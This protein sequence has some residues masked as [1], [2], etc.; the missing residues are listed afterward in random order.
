[1]VKF[2]YFLENSTGIGNQ[3]SFKELIKNRK[4][5]L[6][7]EYDFLRWGAIEA[8]LFTASFEQF[9]EYAISKN[10]LPGT[11]IERLSDESDRVIVEKIFKL[12]EIE[13]FW[14]YFSE[15][16]G[17]LFKNIQ[18]NKS[19]NFETPLTDKIREIIYQKHKIDFDYFNYKIF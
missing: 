19:R 2:C 6:P 14:D 16:T 13:S 9:V 11:L 7:K 5:D 3:E 15:L 12:E 18:E 10:K 4:P 17:T 1:M 8:L